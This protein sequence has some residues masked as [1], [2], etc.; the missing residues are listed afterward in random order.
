MKRPPA[1]RWISAGL[2]LITLAA[3]GKK[4]DTAGS[5][6]PPLPP[7]P[8][9]IVSAEP[10]SFD[11]IAKHLDAGGGLYF[12]LST[13]SFL[14]TASAKLAELAPLALA[15]AKIDAASQARLESGWK[16]LAHFTA[17][18]GLDEISGFGSSSIAL[19]PGYYQ[20]KWMLHHYEG[21][22][23]GL[24]WKLSSATPNALDFAAYLPEK[25]AL[26]SSGNT[27]L[28]PLWNA[29]NQEAAS[30]PDLRQALDTLTQQFQQK[31]GLDL[32]ALLASLGPNYSLVVTLDESRMTTVPGGPNG[33]VSIPE[34]GVALFVQVQ[35]D[36]LINRIDQALAA[37]PMVTKT[38]EPELK[39]RTLA[40]PLPM[41][42]LR[43]TIAWKKGLL[44]LGSSDVLIREMFD[45]KAGKKPGL[46]ATPTFKKYMTGMPASGSS[47]A[48]VSPAFQK[49][50]RD[51]QLASIKQ[52]KNL[53]DPSAQKLIETLSSLSG[54]GAACSVTEETPE[55]WI[56]TTHGNVDP[57]TQI[58]AVGAILPVA[59]IAGSASVAVP[60]FMRARDRSQATQIKGDLH[61]IDLAIAQWAIEWNKA[62]GAQPTTDDIKPY[63]KAGTPLYQRVASAPGAT[64]FPSGITG[65]PNIVLPPVGGKV[66]VPPEIMQKFQNVCPA[67][68]WAPYLLK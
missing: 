36:V 14:K 28:T 50:I 58:A 39:F 5:L 7:A 12:Y 56:G 51:V 29:L 42:F 66:V 30:N 31:A 41:P 37:L 68:F 21:K 35:D 46:A 53:A 62:V 45:V 24:I 52:D 25:T 3:C 9:K 33:P 48:F 43:P 55:G 20:S 8:A 65:A 16:S 17:N 47:F 23:N 11:L 26:A 18:S 67:E 60:N 27:Q 49:T 54:Q 34:P 2:L 57:V 38:D 64:S 13:E 59:I 44:I 32:P 15:S 63:L 40:L 6:P 22:G 61:L 19:E 4:A 1:L 10:T